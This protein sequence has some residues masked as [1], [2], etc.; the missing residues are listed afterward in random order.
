MHLEVVTPEGTAITTEADEVVAPGLRGEFGLLPGHTP[1][2]SALKPGVLSWRPKGERG[3]RSYLAVGA[4]YAEIDGR[5]KV[6][7]LAEDAAFPDG[8]DAA[9]AQ[10]E[11]DEIDR[12]LKEAKTGREAL[13]SQRA[14]AQ[15]RLDAK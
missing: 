8:I 9:A 4:G 6:V 5:D 1:F 15:A 12:A 2:V 11:L 7:V 10:K 13:E 3:K 14:W